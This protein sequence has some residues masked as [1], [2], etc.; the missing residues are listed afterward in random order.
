MK[1]SLTTIFAS[2]SIFVLLFGAPLTSPQAQ[3]VPTP[4]NPPFKDFSVCEEEFEEYL[5]EDYFEGLYIDTECQECLASA[6]TD[7]CLEVHSD[8][9][10]LP[11][12]TDWISCVGWCEAYEGDDD[13]YFQCD[14]A[15]ITNEEVQVDLRICAC[16]MCGVKCRALCGV[17]E[18]Y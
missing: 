9:F 15:F 2:V 10:D 4:E 1:K 11:D 7:G 14:E 18:G 16:D 3:P 6:E 13:C 8:C 17:E 5:V 12:C